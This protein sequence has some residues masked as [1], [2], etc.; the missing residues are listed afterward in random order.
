MIVLKITD[1][2]GNQMFQ[3][4]YARSLQKRLGQRVYLDISD[5]NSH[6]CP[7]Q[8][9]GDMAQFCDTRAYG[10]DDFSTTLPIVKGRRLSKIQKQ[11]QKEHV[12]LRYCREFGLI[13]EYGTR[14]HL[15][16]KGCRENNNVFF[17]CMD[18]YLEGYFFDKIY[19]ENE[20]D[21]LRKEFRLKKKIAVP[22]DIRKA[23][24]EKNTVSVHI[25]RNDFLRIGRDMSDSAYYEK[26]I[27]FM[28]KKVANPFL[29]IFSD[30]I[31]WVK[32]H[33]KFLQG[34]M[35]ISGR[36]FSDGEELMLMSMCK[37]HI[38]A[39]STYSYWGAW[40]N[41]NKEK[42]VVAPGGWKPKTIPETWVLL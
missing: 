9:S 17:R 13:S 11:A 32:N 1:G 41:P 40:L 12:L 14:M 15:D 22:E 21:L 42:I 34:H 18:Y 25:R 37:H 38:I 26:A 36:G 3:Y 20:E 7:N 24:K 5:M 2:L 27:H 30:D 6:L 33:K 10:L 31:E 16:E 4:A 39:N 23:L 19:F 29:V 8:A 28:E 35:Y